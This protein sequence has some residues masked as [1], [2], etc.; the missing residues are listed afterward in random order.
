MELPGEPRLIRSGSYKIGIDDGAPDEGPS[1]DIDVDAFLI[2]PYPATNQEFLDFLREP[3][4]EMWLTEQVQG[5]YGI[6]SKA[7]RLRRLTHIPRPETSPFQVPELILR[8]ARWF[9]KFQDKP[10]AFADR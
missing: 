9:H 5:R 7:C 4:S 1:R 3:G 6:S 10:V 8:A 2:D